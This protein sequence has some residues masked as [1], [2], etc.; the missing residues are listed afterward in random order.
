MSANPVSAAIGRSYRL[1]IILSIFLIVAGVVAIVVPAAASIAAAVFFG[2]ILI[3]GG[4]VHLVYA[5][6]TRGTGAMIWQF[7]IGIVYIVAGGYMLWNPVLG[8]VSLTLALAAY[9][10]AEAVLEFAF[11]LRLKPAQ[12]WAW[13]M[14]DSFITLIL[15]VLI[16]RVWP[17]G[18]LWVVGTLVG[19][20]ILF[21]GVSRLMFSVGAKR[22]AGATA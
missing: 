17:Q 18:S 13:M 14:I 11:S 19:I 12:G 6:H 20:S 1:S 15:A 9:L 4:G 8:T 5:W 2:W 16:W 22:L 3:F 10:F 21:S 7:L